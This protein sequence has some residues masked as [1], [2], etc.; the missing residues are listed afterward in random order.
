M[1]L[2]EIFYVT[3][4]TEMTW[5]VVIAGIERDQILRYFPYAGRELSCE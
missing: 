3:A 5:Q 1:K 2:L 4:V